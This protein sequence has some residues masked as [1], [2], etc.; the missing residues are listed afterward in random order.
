M[1][2]KCSVPMSNGKRATAAG[3]AG[4]ELVLGLS[5]EGDVMG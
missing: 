5:A 3:A 1:P 4:P 2:M